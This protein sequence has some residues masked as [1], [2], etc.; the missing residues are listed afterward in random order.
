[1][2]NILKITIALAFLFS[3]S[4]CWGDK[5]KPNY[6]Y[7][8]DMYKSVG[9]ETYTENPNFSNGMTTQLPVEGTIARGDVPYEYENTNEGYEAA[10]ID[11]KNPLELTEANLDNGK[12]MYDI[13]CMSCH[14]KSG[15]GDGVL[16][17]REKFLG[18]P[19]YKD[20]E[21]TEGSIYHVIMHGRNLMGSHS[22]Q[23]TTKERWQVTMY[24][25]QLRTELL[26]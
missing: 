8:P 26:K 2:K 1:M 6:Q 16:V 22:S 13:Y 23:L 10:K 24:V 14:G 9:Y 18:I 3:L 12:K 11:L 7:M 17:Q 5:S 21:I 25:Q 19:N 15:A 4:S 20:R